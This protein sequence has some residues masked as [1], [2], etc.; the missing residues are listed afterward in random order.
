M[1]HK[2][3]KTKHN[4]SE[5]NT[6][7]SKFTRFKLDQTCTNNKKIEDKQNGENITRKKHGKKENK[8][9]SLVKKKTKQRH[10][11]KINQNRTVKNKTPIFNIAFL[12]FG[13]KLC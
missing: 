1:I 3:K 2:K 7:K 6:N 5:K 4:N 8:Q 11:E 12:C 13:W 9:D 10:K